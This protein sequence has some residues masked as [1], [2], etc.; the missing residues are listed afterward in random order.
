MEFP[1]A[2][3]KE[4]AGDDLYARLS[5]PVRHALVQFDAK[6]VVSVTQELERT[7]IG[8]TDIENIAC[9]L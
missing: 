5:G 8:A 1:Y 6:A 3:V 7:P 4:I 9:R 2:A